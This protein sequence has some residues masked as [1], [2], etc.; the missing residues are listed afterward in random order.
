MALDL[1]RLDKARQ[2][3]P[4]PEGEAVKPDDLNYYVRL[5]AARGDYAEADRFL[6]DAL[7]Q[8][9]QPER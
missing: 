2:L 3:L 7:R 8:A 4:E 5:A 6:A 9:W 1:G